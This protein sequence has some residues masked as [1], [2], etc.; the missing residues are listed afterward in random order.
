MRK[1]SVVAPID[2]NGVWIKRHTVSN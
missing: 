2:V 1:A